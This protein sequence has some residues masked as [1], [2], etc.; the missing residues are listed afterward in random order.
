LHANSRAAKTDA[1]GQTLASAH[2]RPSGKPRWTMRWKP[3]LNAFAI[4]FG[5]RMPK[6]EHL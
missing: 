2:A 1:G 3:A 5:E 6:A 4:T